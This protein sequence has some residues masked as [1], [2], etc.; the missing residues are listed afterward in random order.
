MCSIV[1]PT[2]TPKHVCVRVSM[3]ACGRVYVAVLEVD[4]WLIKC[5]YFAFATHSRHKASV[6]AI[7]VYCCHIASVYA[8]QTHLF[9]RSSTYLIALQKALACRARKQVYIEECYCLMVVCLSA[10]RTP[11][12]PVIKDSGCR[13]ITK[14]LVWLSLGRSMLA[15][16]LYR[17]TLRVLCRYIFV[18]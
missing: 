9:L 1:L 8:S 10:P 15:V 18:L 17:I 12:D 2:W 4:D 11:F 3:C 14:F 7:I 16:I 13:C 5:L 6:K